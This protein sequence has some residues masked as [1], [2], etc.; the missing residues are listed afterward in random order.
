MSDADKYRDQPV[1][2]QV[3][4]NGQWTTKT[5]LPGTPEHDKFLVDL[6]EAEED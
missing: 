6:D 4:E 2:A 3:W 5:V 1:E